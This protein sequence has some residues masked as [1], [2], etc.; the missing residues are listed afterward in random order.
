VADALRALLGPGFRVS[1]IVTT[2]Q[3]VG[4]SLTT[5]DLTGLTR[6]ELAFALS[7]VAGAAGLALALGHAEHRRSYAITAALGARPRQLAA[8]I[9]A[10][11][12]IVTIG[13]LVAGALGGW[14]LTEMLVKVLTHVFDPAPEALSVPWAYLA[15][16]GGLA[17]AAAAV[18]A[19]AATVAARRPGLKLLRAL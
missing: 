13:G 11:T 18:A 9:W 8:F 14:V 1:D 15:V 12:I 6:L 5:V 19:G 7:L 3:F 10:D 4:S 16:A 17:C 2:R